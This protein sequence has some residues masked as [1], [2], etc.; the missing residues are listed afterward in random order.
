[1]A[2]GKS[3]RIAKMDLAKSIKMNVVA[4]GSK[5]MPVVMTTMTKKKVDW[6]FSMFL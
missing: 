2:A 3:V 1:M 5:G 6:E 4:R